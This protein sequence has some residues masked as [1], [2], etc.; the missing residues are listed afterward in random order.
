MDLFEYSDWRNDARAALGAVY[1]DLECRAIISFFDSITED[2]EAELTGET[3]QK[4]LNVV[5]K[6]L[7]K[8]QGFNLYH[9]LM[10]RVWIYAPLIIKS[11]EEGE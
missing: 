5:R 3:L 2:R 10:V 7:A 4:S 8:A 11:I 9:D 6:E 1:D